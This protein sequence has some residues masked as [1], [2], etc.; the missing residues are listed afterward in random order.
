MALS[1]FFSSSLNP[2]ELEDVAVDSPVVDV[3]VED[4]EELED[5][6]TSPVVDVVTEVDVAVVTV[7]D[8]SG[9]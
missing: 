8:V 3:E 7:V 4:D 5:D 6:V 2:V 9:L 1:L